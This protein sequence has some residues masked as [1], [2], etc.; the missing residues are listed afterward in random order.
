MGQ[1]FKAG[2]LDNVVSVY[3]QTKTTIQ[4]RVT[5][6]TIGG[7][8]VLGPPLTKFIDVFTDTAQTPSG[9][10]RVTQNNR[11]FV[12]AAPVN[13]TTYDTLPI[14][15]YD[16]S[17]STGAYAYV[18]RIDIQLP[19]LAATVHT[20][21]GLR[22]TNDSGNTGWRIFVATTA[23]VNINGGL[24]M[25]NN[26]D[27]ADFI[28]VGF[29][30]IPMA[31]SS[32]AK[33]VYKLE[34]P[35]NIGVNQLNI[36]SVGMINDIPNGRM[37]VHNGVSATHQYYVY[38]SVSN[39]VWNSNAVT[40]ASG[41]PGVIT[42]VGNPYNNNDPVIV[43]SLT[44]GT[45]LTNNLVYFV[46]NKSGNTYELSLTS[47]GASVAVT[48]AGT[49]VIGR[50]W[51][52]VGSNWVFKTGNLPALSGTL[53]AT[54]SEEYAV[55]V[56]SPINGG[57]L[58][59]FPCAFLGT[60]TSLYLGLL[61]D[62]TSGGTTWPSLSTSNLLGGTN[63]ITA[64]T[65]TQ[66]MWG[67]TI[68]AATYI[69]NV[70]KF[71]TKKL[72]NNVIL[73][74]FG[75]LNNAYYEGAIRDTVNLGLV[76]VSSA[77]TR[78]GWLFASGSTAGQRGVVFVDLRSDQAYDYSYIVTK[79]LTNQNAKLSF[80]STWEKLYDFTGN[81]KLQY[82]NSGF[83]SITGGWIDVPRG[84]DLSGLAMSSDQIQFKILFFVQSEGSSSPAQLNELLIANDSNVGIS[85]NWEFS[86]DWSD[87]N[88]PSRC[89]FRLKAAYSVS[90]P[91]LY[92][93]AYDLSNT[94]LTTANTVSNPANFE[95]STNNGVSW[96][97]LGTIPNVVG[98]LIRYTFTSPP[99]VD[100]RPGLKES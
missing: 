20:I 62:L 81:S 36:A 96:L 14:L 29:P 30:V 75:E 28:P 93:R 100:I 42:D 39:P 78:N 10:F 17:L 35:A 33:A 86:D 22:I 65:A 38:D 84:M 91:T 85:D 16:F 70:S 53:L 6:K 61:S 31:T 55:P 83:G 27:K 63:E 12:L 66:A 7:Q 4:G 9:S 79:V 73:S 80:Y 3:D 19:N 89:A 37:Y 57:V 90:V 15:L 98:T 24:F 45:G 69:T 88:T 82:R 23:T 71:I 21:R 68:D 77:Q 97:P 13:G 51:G 92:F 50:A 87:N 99:G 59:G 47:G 76:T 32:N 74:N 43:T 18:G 40:I 34:D 41:T 67:N 44:G 2:L 26:I 54:D 56:S 49:A 64:P 46:R 94:L 5:Q 95:Y 52:T 1:W 58:N 8:S 11:M 72:Q 48:L 25:A 60:S